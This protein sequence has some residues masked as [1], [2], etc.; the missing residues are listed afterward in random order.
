MFKFLFFIYFTFTIKNNILFLKKE[1]KNLYKD[2]ENILI[3][4]NY[5]IILFNFKEVR[6]LFV[7]VK[8]FY[9]I[10]Q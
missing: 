8:Y 10:C 1:S 2:S 9:C 4:I 6:I 5:R 3:K 7:W